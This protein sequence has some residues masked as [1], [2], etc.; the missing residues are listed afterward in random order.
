K[1]CTD[2]C[3]C[4]RFDDNCVTRCNRWTYFVCNEI[5]WIVKRCNRCYNPDRKLII[6]SDTIFRTWHLIER[7][8]F[9]FDTSSFLRRNSYRLDCSC[10]FASCFINCFTT[11]FS[12]HLGIYYM[13]LLLIISCSFL[14]IFLS[15]FLSSS[16]VLIASSISSFPAFRTVVIK[17]LSCGSNTLIFSSFSTHLPPSNIFLL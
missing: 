13:I 3:K 1:K 2:W 9:A 8:R 7:N 6:I 17:R 15:I 10:Y 12:Y 5:K 4:R 11:F 14:Y 16:V